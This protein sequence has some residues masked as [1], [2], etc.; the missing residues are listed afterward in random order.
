M[1]GHT[2]LQV[3]GKVEITS[4]LTGDELVVQSPR[5]SLHENQPVELSAQNQ[6]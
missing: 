5:A 2:G 6:R 3:G 1:Y 4:G